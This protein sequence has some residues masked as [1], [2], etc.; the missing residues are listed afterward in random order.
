METVAGIGGTA[1]PKPRRPSVWSRTVS[2]PSEKAF[3]A[4]RMEKVTGCEKRVC[5]SD[6]TTEGERKGNRNR[7]R[8][9]K[10]KREKRGWRDK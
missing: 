7:R 6:W 3:P 2:T 8:T 4:G 10:M 9:Q 1:N 5:E